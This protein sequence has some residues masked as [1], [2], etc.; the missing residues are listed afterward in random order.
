[1]TSSYSDILSRI[2][3]AFEAARVVFAEFT[4]GAVEAEFKAGHDPVTEADRAVDAACARICCAR[5]KAGF[6]KR[7]STMFRDWRRVRLGGR[8]ARWYSRIRPGY[9]G[10]LRLD[11]VCGEWTPR[12]RRYLQS[13]DER[14]DHRG[15]RLRDYL[16]R[17][18]CSASQTESLT[19]LSDSGQPQRNEA[20]RVAAVS[21][22]GVP[23]SAGGFGR[24]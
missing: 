14:N 3:V 21:K 7:A 20:R 10:I 16:Q 23:D 5:A 6:R 1:M 22:W 12:G 9:P 19:R 17:P 8:S 24:L 15:S 4:P 2:E 13:R 18:S 11:W